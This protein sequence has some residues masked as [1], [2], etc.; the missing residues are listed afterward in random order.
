[1]LR[2]LKNGAEDLMQLNNKK[3]TLK[4]WVCGML[5]RERGCAKRSKNSKGFTRRNRRERE[6]K[7]WKTFF[8]AFNKK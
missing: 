5:E 2:R 3:T 6:R 7:K 8:V 1:M 4:I